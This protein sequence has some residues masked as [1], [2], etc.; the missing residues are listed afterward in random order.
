[1]RALSW[2]P[3][4]LALATRPA[5]GEDVRTVNQGRIH[6]GDLVPTVPAS[7]ADIDLGPSPPP[8]GSR[9]VGRDEMIVAI[10]HAGA[11]PNT[12]RLPT[13]VRAVAASRRIASSELRAMAAEEIPKH[14]RSGVELKKVEDAPDVVVVP[15]AT[16]RGASVSFIPYQKGESRA[17]AVLELA[18]DDVTVAS[19]PLTLVVEVLEAGSHPDV[20]RGALVNLVI[21]RP[22]MRVSAPG[23][24][25]A[26]ANVGDSVIFHVA[27]T[28]RTVRARVSSRDEAVVL[29]S[30]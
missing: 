25:A 9:L 26:D 10:R 7:M 1:M 17:T 11:F 12:T 22:S 23:T 21:E 29:E 13:A 15:G 8:G 2:L 16:V 6:L 24:A 14:L 3:L 19:V 18:S 27:S 5:F 20:K 28:G 30:P 4:V